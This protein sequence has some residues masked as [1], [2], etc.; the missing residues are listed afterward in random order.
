[1]IFDYEGL[2][3]DNERDR[4]WIIQRAEDAREYSQRLSYNVR[5]TKA[6]QRARGEWSQAAPYGLRAN[7]KTRKLSPDPNTWRFVVFMF[8]AIALGATLRNVAAHLNRRGVKGGRGGDWSAVSI[9]QII[10]SPLY[11]GWQIE[12]L[13]GNR[14]VRVVDES[15]SPVRVFAE[16]A[17]TIPAEL[18]TRARAQMGGH[19]FAVPGR[20][21]ATHELT[22]FMHCTGCGSR[23]PCTG[24][25][26]RCG[27]HNQGQPCSA[28]AL[29]NKRRAEEHVVDRWVAWLANSEPGDPV[30]VAVAERWGA[31]TAPEQSEEA[32]EAMTALKMAQA[33]AQALADDYAEGRFRGAL[34]KHFPRLEAEVSSRLAAAQQRV[35]E[36]SQ[37]VVDITVLLDEETA[38]QLYEAADVPTRRD[39]L[40]V[41]ID[42]IDVKRAERMGGPIDGDKRITITWA[43]V[44]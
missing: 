37:P 5:A 30:Q 4:R 3:S 29:I 18:A 11:E 12:R 1:M 10:M 41:A 34:A 39:L 20:G 42:R 31:L 25:V 14:R 33:D 43:E 21:R 7:P 22:G 9:W 23:M 15:G 2:D 6:R 28:P 24:R 17:A 16:E 40:R 27:R 36:Y 44:T 38:R 35:A 8:R 32:L 13:Q 26:Y 19:G